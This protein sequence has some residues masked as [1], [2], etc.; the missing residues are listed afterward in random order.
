MTSYRFTAMP[1]TRTDNGP[2][3]CG[4]CTYFE[5]SEDLQRLWA[6]MEAYPKNINELKDVHRCFN[7]CFIKLSIE[8]FCDSSKEWVRIVEGLTYCDF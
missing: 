8:K 7:A 3:S 5:E 2:K 6:Q 4:Q 1:Y